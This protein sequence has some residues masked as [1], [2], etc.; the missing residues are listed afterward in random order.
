MMALMYGLMTDEDEPEDYPRFIGREI[1]SAVFGGVPFVRDAAGAFNGYGGGGV[2]GSVLEVPAN[3][4]QQAT[5]MENDRA[6][7]RAIGDVVGI[8]TG[9]PTTA[10]LR[11]M[12][13]IADPDEVSPAEALFGS[14]PL[15]R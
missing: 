6:L 2:Y 14:N 12:E 5:Q 9:L 13:W 4:Y 1:G 3:L 8:A 7:R 10:T 15:T 11:G